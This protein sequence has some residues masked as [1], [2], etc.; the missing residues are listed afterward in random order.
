MWKSQSR[1]ASPPDSVSLPVKACRPRGAVAKCPSG[2]VHEESTQGS[3]FLCPLQLARG[4]VAVMRQ[5]HRPGATCAGRACLPQEGLGS[6]GRSWGNQTSLP[7][8]S[9]ARQPRVLC[10]GAISA[11]LCDAEKAV[12]QHLCSLSSGKCGGLGLS[13][14]LTQDSCVTGRVPRIVRPR[15]VSVNMSRG[16]RVEA[17]P[18]VWPVTGELAARS[19]GTRECR[20]PV[21]GPREV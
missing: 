14:R 15:W 18:H 6:A 13:P 12:P 2:R 4:V 17:A 10:R 16:F 11:P 1:G 21:W 8:R 7:P 19:R 20:G 3:L 9:P 5:G